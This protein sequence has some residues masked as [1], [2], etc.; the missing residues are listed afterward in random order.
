MARETSYL[1]CGGLDQ[2]VELE[3]EALVALKGLAD[4]IE[5]YYGF[6]MGFKADINAATASYFM[7]VA[8]RSL[9]E[10]SAIALLC[11]VDPLRVVLSSK[12]QSS[13][14]YNKGQQQASAI[15]WRTDI[16]G[17]KAAPLAPGAPAKTLWDPS[18]SSQKL[19]R[20]LLS[21][22]MCE[23]I[24]IPAVRNFSNA[25]D[26]P[27][28]AWL[29]ELL[30]STPAELPKKLIGEGNQVYSE[31]SKG[32]HPEFAVR[33]EAEYD[34]PTLLTYMEKVLKWVASLGLLSHYAFSFASR[35]PRNDAIAAFLVI[36]GAAK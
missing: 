24:W 11:R 35:V 4:L 19:P 30:S 22:H 6:C 33:R 5:S 25:K 17:D 32:I 2:G 7:P 18:L 36:E 3:D 1:A 12:S 27:D 28:S 29:K 9:M 13:G 31:L 14:T 10:A 23:A 16:V 15:G 34:G 8:L 26:L 21:E 20:Q